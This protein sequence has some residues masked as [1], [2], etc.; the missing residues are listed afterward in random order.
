MI[1]LNESEFHF[2]EQQLPLLIHGGHGMWASQFTVSTAVDFFIQWKK[3]LLLTAYHMA[4]D[5][6]LTMVDGNVKHVWLVDDEQQYEKHY[7]DRQAI[8]LKSWDELLFQK[9]WP[10]IKD[11][12]ERIIILKN[13]E[14]FSAETLLL[15][16]DH[17][18][19]IISGD[20]D[21][22]PSLEL[23]KSMKFSSHIFFSPSALV[24]DMP[25]LEKYQG[26]YVSGE[27]KGNMHI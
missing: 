5:K 15:V 3:I 13:V 18:K 22:S 25:M 23:I 8:I 20:I 26:W 7:S 27:Q 11:R 17:T 14:T 6:F 9:L 1:Y 12:E 16:K 21:K 24:T 19:L 4:R 2:A 10:I